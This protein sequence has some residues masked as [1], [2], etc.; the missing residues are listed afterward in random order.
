MRTGVIHEFEHVLFLDIVCLC[1]LPYTL[2]LGY[3]IHGKMF[4]HDHRLQSRVARALSHWIRDSAVT[5]GLTHVVTQEKQDFRNCPPNTC[6]GISIALRQA[7]A[8]AAQRN[9]GRGN[10]RTVFAQAPVASHA[11]HCDDTGTL[12]GHE[13]YCFQRLHRRVG[14]KTPWITYVVFEH[15][16]WDIQHIKHMKSIVRA[17]HDCTA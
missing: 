17:T 8:M 6:V 14:I 13:R 9:Q 10:D 4:E 1:V 3:I 2:T 5:Q 16:L 12:Q 7:T 15:V 11:Q